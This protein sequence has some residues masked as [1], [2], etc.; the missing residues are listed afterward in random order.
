VKLY[1]LKYIVALRNHETL[2]TVEN[3][4]Y[5]LGK[6]LIG[7]MRHFATI[8]PNNSNL[9]SLESGEQNKH[10]GVIVIFIERIVMKIFNME[11]EMGSTAIIY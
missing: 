1:P 10:G 8:Y 9:I 3:P 7:K 2:R 4:F 6:I 5:F 11:N